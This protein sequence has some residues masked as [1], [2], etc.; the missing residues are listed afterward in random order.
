LELV[1]NVVEIEALLT[2]KGCGQLPG[3]DVGCG[4]PRSHTMAS[5]E[6]NQ[7]TASRFGAKYSSILL[8]H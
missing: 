2:E 5:T 8:A 1:N 7:A 3:R 6:E 4:L